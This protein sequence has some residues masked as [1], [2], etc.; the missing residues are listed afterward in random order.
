MQNS[1]RSNKEIVAGFIDEVL[2][3]GNIDAA[4]KYFWEDMVEQVPFPGQGPGLAG[5]KDLLRGLRSA[6]PDMHWT[7]DE[8]I[9]EGDKVVTRFTWTGTHRGPFMGM[10]PT[11]KPVTVWG[12]VI[13]RLEDGR[14]KETRILMDALGMMMQLGAIPAP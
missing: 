2:S 4:G 13:D 6:F 3:G 9:A 1:T 10:P 12:T 5:L 8:Q 14:I 11:E 7:I